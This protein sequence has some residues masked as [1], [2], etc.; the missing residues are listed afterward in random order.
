MNYIEKIYVQLVALAYY[1][2]GVQDTKR[3]SLKKSRRR[4][5]TTKTK[6]AILLYQGFRCRSCSCILHIREFDHIDGNKAN[7]RSINCQALCPNC[8][9]IKTKRKNM[10]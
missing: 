9:R 4:S 5:F 2:K 8:H 3:S 10:F 1:N 6:Q 7:N